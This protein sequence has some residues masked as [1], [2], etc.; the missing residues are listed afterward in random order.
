M[1]APTTTRSQVQT[2]LPRGNGRSVYAGAWLIPATI[3]LAIVVGLVLR[4]W[5][6]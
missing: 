2:T 5:L 1:S 6:R 4:W 3:L